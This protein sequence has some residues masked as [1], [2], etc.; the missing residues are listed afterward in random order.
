MDII[1]PNL[2]DGIESAVVISILVSS[3]DTVTKDQTILELETDKAV[4][5][6]GAEADGVISSITIKE[7]DTTFSGDKMLDPWM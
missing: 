1:I 2:G 6:V 7:G 3:G 4:A 5:P